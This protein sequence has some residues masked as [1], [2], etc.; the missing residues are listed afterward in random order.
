M[1]SILIPIYNGVEYLEESITSVCQ[2]TISDW[3]VIIG[4]NGYEPGSETYTSAL[5]TISRLDEIYGSKIK[6]IE[7][8]LSIKGKASTLNEMLKEC[9]YDWIAILDVDDKWH[10]RKLEIQKTLALT[11]KFDVIGTVC[12]Y[13]GTREDIPKIPVGDISTFNF[14]KVNPMINSSTV[15]KKELCYWRDQYNGGFRG[16]DD[17]DLWIRLW[18]M[19]KKFLNIP[20][21][22]CYHRIHP[23]SAFNAKGNHNYVADLIKSHMC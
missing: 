10:R 13:F 3:E 18:K 8:P 9:N 19:K 1:F 21:I 6:I 17:Y 14:Y 22:L 15:I 12:Q 11:D 5:N 7:Y 2:Q 4:I 16:L 23:E 20:S